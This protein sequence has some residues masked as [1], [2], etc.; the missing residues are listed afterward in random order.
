MH[1]KKIIF[2]I[3]SVLMVAS[4]LIAQEKADESYNEWSTN[5]IRKDD[6]MFKKALWFRLDLRQKMNVGFFSDNNEITR[7]LIDAVKAGKIRPFKNDSLTSRLSYSDFLENVQL[8][9]AE[10][11][12]ALA[13]GETWD[14]DDVWTEEEGSKTKAAIAP[15]EYLPKQ[16]YLLEIKEDLIF[17]NRRSRMYHDILA[18]T[19]VVPAEQTPTGIERVVASFSYKELAQDLFANN[20]EAI[21]YNYQNSAQHHN[22]TDAFTLRLFDGMLVKYENPKNNT[23]VDMYQGGRKAV[24]MSQQI[25][26]QLMEYEATLWEE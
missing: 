7:L 22:L 13:K 24:M 17:D 15:A 19:I 6:Q 25:L 26:Y 5:P 16:L 10:D 21:W 1:T 14:N 8:P 11:E 23:L 2:I 4:G 12:D 18:I 3:L 9:T 20:P